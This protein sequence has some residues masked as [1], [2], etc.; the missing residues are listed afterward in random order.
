M[1]FAPATTWSLVRIQPRESYT[2]PDPTDVSPAPPSVEIWTTAG[3]TRLAAAMIVEAS[4][5]ID[6]R[7]PVPVPG[8]DVAVSSAPEA[9]RA[10][11]VPAE[12]MIAAISDTASMVATRPRP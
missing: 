1:V 10:R 2:I 4:D 11:Y 9:R 7:V 5:S 3:P 8:I 12:P 6:T